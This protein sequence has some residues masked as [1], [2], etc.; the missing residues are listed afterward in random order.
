MECLV[1]FATVEQKQLLAYLLAQLS[2]PFDQF[3]KDLRFRGHRFR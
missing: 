1:P 3:L 2:G